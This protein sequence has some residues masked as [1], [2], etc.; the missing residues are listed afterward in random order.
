MGSPK[1]TPCT[2]THVRTHSRNYVDSNLEATISSVCPSTLGYLSPKLHLVALSGSW[3]WR[4]A[5]ALPALRD[6]AV[7]AVGREGEIYTG[8]HAEAETKDG[9]T[10]T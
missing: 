8:E 10:H 3:P 6:G 4:G 7:G 9:R 2:Q 5:V 1:V